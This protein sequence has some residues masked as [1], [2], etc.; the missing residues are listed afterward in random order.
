MTVEEVYRE[1]WGRILSA[2]ISAFGDFDLAE[3]ALQEAFASAVREWPSRPP[4]NA[5][6]WLYTAAR[7]NAIDQLRRR[8]NFAGKMALVN[9]SELVEPAEE[10]AVPDD[11][12]RLIFTCCHPSLAPEAQ[13]ALTLRTLCGLTT[14]EIA[15]AFLVP[16][17]TMA[18]RL[19]R[20]KAKIRDAAI[21]YRVPDLDELPERVDEVMTVIYLVFNE[22]YS[23]GRNDLSGEAIRL[24]RLLR[25]LLQSSSAELDSLL[26]LMLLHHSRR[27]ARIDAEGDLVLLADQ[28]RG[29]WDR[30]EI[31]EGTALVERAMR[32]GHP[33]T[34]TIE[35]A[36]AALHTAPE[37]DWR[38]IAA[39]YE[40]LFEMLPSPVVALNRAVAVSMSE[41]PEA[42]LP[43]LADLE[44]ELSEYHLFH[45]TRADLLKRLG[46]NRDA[47]ESYQRA[48]ALASTDAERRF[49]KKRISI[50]SE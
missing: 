44:E 24:A 36:I 40:R 26:A 35:A 39:L 32:R 2:L 1:E 19:V 17:K 29:K 30:L 14:E 11:R 47:I 10:D 49:L 38:Q 37:T 9:V 45:A 25:E 6:G 16:V 43:L 28:D 22:G 42:A 18:Q 27:D 5:R 4:S 21:P 31:A 33:G 34:Y 15:R 41:G 7:H 12:L 46:R 3:D 13:V 50:L 23:G 20:A 48:L 8:K